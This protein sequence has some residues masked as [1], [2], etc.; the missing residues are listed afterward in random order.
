MAREA[1]RFA[2]VGAGS[3]A[4]HIA[5]ASTLL[6]V[7]G[8]AAGEANGLA[9]MVATVASYWLNTMW[10][11]DAPPGLGSLLRYALV[12]TI[13]LIVTVGIASAIERVGYRYWVGIALVVTIV[14]ALTFVLHR[15]WTY[16][17]R[18]VVK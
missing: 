17:A 16:R 1:S 6:E 8:Y 3:T 9:F 13:G 12:A 5:V 14:P 2:V 4:L 7:G 15:L 10:T 18:F 11:F